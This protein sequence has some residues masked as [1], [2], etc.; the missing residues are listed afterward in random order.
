MEPRP[1]IGTANLRTPSLIR[2]QVHQYIYVQLLRP[3]L[4]KAKEFSQVVSIFLRFW[5]LLLGST[6]A[7]A[8]RRTLMKLT[9]C[10]KFTHSLYVYIT[11]KLG[12]WFSL[13]PLKIRN[14]GEILALLGVSGRLGKKDTKTTKYHETYININRFVAQSYYWLKR[15]ATVWQLNNNN[16]DRWSKMLSSSSAQDT[17]KLDGNQI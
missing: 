6:G 17:D 9:P 11:K 12:H 5:D 16:W 14:L 13:I 8:A 2:Y 15:V 3:K 1:D 10:I 4:P 7:K